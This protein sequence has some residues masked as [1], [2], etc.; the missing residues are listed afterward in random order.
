MGGKSFFFTSQNSVDAS[1]YSEDK[2]HLSPSHNGKWNYL[3][4][5]RVIAIPAWPS[6]LG[7]PI[8]CDTFSIDCISNQ[9]TNTRRMKRVPISYIAFVVKYNEC[10]VLFH[11][12]R[13]NRCIL[14]GIYFEI[15]MNN[16][17]IYV[18]FFK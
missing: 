1:R 14:Y 15:L 8:N 12:T 2:R 10:H 9:R 7:S 18:V 17:N 11:I 13:V 4:Q 6:S 3:S 5:G 16:I